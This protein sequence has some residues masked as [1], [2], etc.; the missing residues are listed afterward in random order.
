V[1]T[2]AS[3]GIGRSAAVG[4]ARLGAELVLV[5]RS[6]GRLAEAAEAALLAGAPSA[7][8]AA[9]DVVDAEAVAAFADRLSSRHQRVHGLIHGAGALARS[10]ER[11]PDGTEL[12]VATHV[13]APFRL[14][15]LLS[16]LLRR[17]DRSVVVTVSSGGMYAEPF[18]LDRLEMGAEE[19]EGVRAYARAKRA[20][21]VLSHEWA[22]RFG[23][24]HVASHAMHPGWADTHGLS[25]GLPAFRHF[26]WLL[27]TPDQGADTAVWLAAGGPHRGALGD[28]AAAP[29]EGF[30]LDRRRRP[31]YR[32][33]GARP[34]SA[35]G[36]AGARLW[37]WC[38][39]RTGL[40]HTASQERRR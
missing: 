10:F 14:T 12:T 36:D 11:T 15:W 9:V 6:S 2:G 26:R 23:G 21:V 38:A 16:P 34:A 32:C 30:W 7:E 1:V 13:L 25:A 19:Y 40:G 31:E 8:T 39:E 20:Q 5:G 28:D 35:D 17:S 3:S 18:D 4:L 22:R 37:E 33:P 24:D 29:G 27:R